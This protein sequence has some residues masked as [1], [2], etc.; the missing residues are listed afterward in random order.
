MIV[1]VCNAIR[2]DDVRRAARCGASCAESAYRALGFEPQ[3]RSCLCHADDIVREERARPI[4]MVA[5]A[6]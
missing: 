3:C 1:C 5:R 2:E 4:R 6:A